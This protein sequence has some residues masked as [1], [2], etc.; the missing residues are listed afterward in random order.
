MIYKCKCEH[1][2]QDKLHSKGMRVFNRIITT[3]PNDYKARCTVCGKEVSVPVDLYK[4]G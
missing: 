4:K 1:K 2:S 3:K